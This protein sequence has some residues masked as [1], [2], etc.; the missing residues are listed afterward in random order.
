MSSTFL[1]IVELANGSFVLKRTDSAD[2]PLV[3]IDFSKE[4]QSILGE[5]EGEIAKIMISAGIQAYAAIAQ[6]AAESE[7]S[8]EEA[9][10]KTV[11]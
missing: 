9:L 7:L 2:A 11:H 1:E 5:H 8:E 10:S 3:K 6:Q 4:A